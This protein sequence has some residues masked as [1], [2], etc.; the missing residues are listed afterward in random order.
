MVHRTSIESF[1]RGVLD[2][3]AFSSLDEVERVSIQWMVDY[4]SDRPH[5][6]PGRHDRLVPQ[7]TGVAYQH[8]RRDDLWD[9]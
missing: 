7:C 1:R 5:Q 8:L 6:F 4:N 2:L 3:Y 9:R